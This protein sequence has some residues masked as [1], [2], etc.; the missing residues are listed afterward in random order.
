MISTL[1][2]LGVVLA[3]WVAAWNLRSI[4][5][6]QT[7][8]LL[9]SYLFYSN[10]GYGFLAILIMSSLLNFGIGSLLRRQLSIRYL[11]LGIA[12]NVG[13]LFSFKYLPAIFATSGMGWQSDLAHRILMPVGLSFWT[14]QALSYLIDTYLEEEIDPSL[15]EFS[16]YMAFWPTVLSGPVCRLPAMLPQFR[17]EPAFSW[18]NV[19]DGT[20]LIV[21]GF[22]M[23][24][25]LAQL[26]AL[27]WTP[28]GGVVAG[29]DQLKSGWGGVDVWLLGIGFGFQLF[30]DFAG[31]SLMAIG[32]ARVFGIELAANFNRPFLSETPAVFW[33]RWHMSLSFWIRDYVFKPLA[34]ARRDRWWPHLSLV[35]S[36]VLFGVWHGAKWTFVAFGAYHGV[37]LVVH[38]LGQKMK[39]YR[40]IQPPRRFGA[41]MSWATTFG[42]VALGF[43]LFRA[44]NLGQAGSMLRAVFSPASYGHFAMPLNFY[45]LTMTIAAGYFV[46]TA[47]H[48]LS[49][50]LRARY[51]EAVHPSQLPEVAGGLMD[52]IAAKLWWWLA[53]A[54]V[55]LA[56]FVALAMY[57]QSAAIRTTPFIYALF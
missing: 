3:M 37:L 39:A 25:Y 41:L 14:F 4:R 30:F 26:L 7:L 5:A 10:W 38:R 23:K 54:L 9:A 20:F 18:K 16:L 51:N 2:V 21:Q 15:L 42:L 49:T 6:R 47:G 55:S 11:W 27:G 31:Y 24:V 19:S 34:F 48:S 17:R 12:V 43:V 40:L 35:V 45:V 46:V 52:F 22:F 28:G 32:V 1:T 50:S 33:T 13:L 44:N 29:F 53:P 57:T 56:L 36:M 8:L